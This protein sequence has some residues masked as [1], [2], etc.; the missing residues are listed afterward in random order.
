MSYDFKT[1]DDNDFERLVKDIFSKKLGKQIERFK[2]GRDGGIDLRHSHFTDDETI[3]QCKH[4]ANSRFSNLKSVIKREE[5]KKVKKLNPK[6]YIFVTSLPLNDNEKTEIMKLF[7]PYIKNK[8]DIIGCEDLNDDLSTYSEIEARHYK[9]WLH[10][11]S[12]ITNLLNGM[13]HNRT[14]MV[15]RG[16]SKRIVKYVEP[17][18]FNS[19][20]EI[21]EQNNFIIITGN[22][23]VGKSTIS[24]ILLSYYLKNNFTP[25]VI[26]DINEAL[27]LYQPETKQVFLFDDFLGQTKINFKND[28]PDL[29]RLIKDIKKSSNT[30]LI[31]VSRE[32]ILQSGRQ[33]SDILKDKHFDISKHVVNVD[34]LSQKDKADILYNHFKFSDIPK[35]YIEYIIQNQ[36]YVEII[37]HN[38]FFP[39]II[40]I[41]TDN[42][43]ISE[44]IIRN[45]QEFYKKFIESLNN[46]YEIW[47]GLYSQ[48]SR[49][50]K[51]LLL[52][53]LTLEDECSIQGLQIAFKHYHR[54][55][56]LADN[57]PI[58]ENAFNEAISKINNSF[59]RI[60]NQS[61]TSIVV[62][63]NP[64]VKDFL[65][66]IV[67]KDF[68]DQYIKL[69]IENSVYVDQIYFIKNLVSINKN[70]NFN[71][72]I[73]ERLFFVL[74]NYRYE[75]Y[76]DS[77][78]EKEYGEKGF[79][80]ALQDAVYL[81]ID[82][83]I[84]DESR[85]IMDVLKLGINYLSVEKNYFNY[86]DL[87][88]LFF[89]IE[90]YKDLSILKETENKKILDNIFI[91][92][93]DKSDLFYYYFFAHYYNFA[94][95]NI[96]SFKFNEVMQEFNKSYKTILANSDLKNDYSENL[97]RTWE[98]C[99]EVID[100][101][102][103]FYKVD[104]KE[105]KQE[106][107]EG[108]G[109]EEIRDKITSQKYNEFIKGEKEK[110]NLIFY[111]IHKK[112]KE[113][114]E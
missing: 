14:E 28:D 80:K 82:L 12:L 64:S 7:N 113:L 45:P 114:I 92:K 103:S 88:F 67:Y 106:I 47:E 6:R 62:F 4:Y 34:D 78:F 57:Q 13:T 75:Q 1:L 101:L 49:E 15:L 9:L 19:I 3:F 39:R 11:I 102:Q 50:S 98:E 30:K 90:P 63:N 111:H 68:D 20:L 24:E 81:I 43:L 72:D 108:I 18:N 52:M 100:F 76:A 40:E 23:G 37:K 56:S 8:S 51:D 5:Y 59:I 86:N 26:K 65:E 25:Y 99:F 32:N 85:Y 22:P 110:D 91:K 21:I 109:E 61:D 87:I 93:L 70:S 31:L 107:L 29:L 41:M 46:P 33:S 94:P 69:I 10:N 48:I 66:Q 89:L 27:N 83:E 17:Q 74:K 84:N 38:N 42:L 77:F 71:K 58:N 54:Q 112:Y 104:F 97:E 2:P 53:L 55:K 96:P 79:L 35:E 73:I 95:D 16:I 36:H 44:S 60:E 105:E